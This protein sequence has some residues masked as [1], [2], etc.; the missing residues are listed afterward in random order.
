MPGPWG[1]GQSRCGGEGLHRGRP[2]GPNLAKIR[3][4]RRHPTFWGRCARKA[5]A[6]RLVQGVEKVPPEF[7]RGLF[8]PCAKSLCSAF[9]SAQLLQRSLQEPERPRPGRA[10]VRSDCVSHERGR[11][12][13]WRAGPGRVLVVAPRS[14][15]GRRGAAG[16]GLSVPP[17][18]PPVPSGLRRGDVKG[19]G[20]HGRGVGLGRWPGGVASRGSSLPPGWTVRRGRCGGR[21]CRPEA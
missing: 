16:P 15:G 3:L 5:E 13:R 10:A 4:P 14:P 1:A 9:S 20:G 2:P 8:L 19:C 17:M 7:G 6:A 18:A 11:R 21:S 12:A